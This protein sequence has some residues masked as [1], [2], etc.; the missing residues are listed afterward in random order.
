MAVLDEAGTDYVVRRY[1]ED[2][3]TPAELGAVLERLALEPWDLAR[4]REA[5]EA[6]IDLPRAPCSAHHHRR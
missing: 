4:P 3:P 5:T 6:R 2:P 1:L